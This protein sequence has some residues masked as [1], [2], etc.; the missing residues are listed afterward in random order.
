MKWV[1]FA[2]L[3]TAH[4]HCSAQKEAPQRFAVTVLDVGRALR[5]SGMTVADDQILLP[6]SI[7]SSS[8]GPLLD[9]DSVEPLRGG[10][11]SKIKL[12]CH[13][14]KLCVPF[15]AIADLPQGSRFQ[16]AS[17]ASALPPS[18]RAGSKAT[19]LVDTGDMHIQVPVICLQNGVIGASI[20]V[21]SPDRKQNY[22]ATIVS[23]T[24]LRGSL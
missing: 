14:P 23:S 13:S 16:A 6:A 10:L 5:H 17:L 19:L 2:F 11:R 1:A 21:V 3:I 22:T 24:L 15:Y 9:V 4:V 12:V 18:M 7:V 8:S 20:H